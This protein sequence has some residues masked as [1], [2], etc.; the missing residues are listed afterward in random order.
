MRLK[1]STLSIFLSC[2][3]LSA[4]LQPEMAQRA[5][6]SW[7]ETGNKKSY[8]QLEVQ[9]GRK[10]ITIP[11]TLRSEII[12]YHKA[13]GFWP[14]SL[15]GLLAAG[16]REALLAD[17]KNKGYRDILFNQQQDTLLVYFNFEKLYAIKYSQFDDDTPSVNLIPGVW[18]FYAD[19]SHYQFRQELLDTSNKFI[20]IR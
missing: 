14:F 6:G 4:C 11:A 5:D 18:R 9:R 7:Y 3:L 20:E 10:S 2:L 12:A 8:P 1:S 15:E 13:N 16:D 17:L 19:S